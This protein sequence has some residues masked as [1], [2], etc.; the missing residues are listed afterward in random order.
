MPETSTAPCDGCPLQVERA[1]ASQGP[2]PAR[3]LFLSGAPRY[4]EEK[5]GVAFASPAFSWLEQTLAEA[6]LD[7]ATVHY[8]TLTGCRPPYQR[9]LRPAEIEACAPRLDLMINALQGA[10]VVLCGPDVAAAV[11]PGVA[12]ATGHGV[13]VRRGHRR[14]YPIRHPYAALLSARYGDEVKAD[15]RALVTL[16]AAGP[17]DLS[18]LPDL[19]ATAMH[20]PSEP[21]ANDGFPQPSPLPVITIAPDEPP[22]D[23]ADQADQLILVGAPIADGIPVEA[24]EAAE[25]IDAPAH[26]QLSAADDGSADVPAATAEVAPA[27]TDTDKDIDADGP[28]QLSLF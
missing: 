9:P 22:A 25:T 14:Y 26:D 19:A 6:G 18:T 7:P 27:V 4:H 15:L 16:L 21:A 3:V 12:L 2:V 10:V 28:T 5:E 23:Q 1:V 13:L 11:L 24:V 20:P 8:A 17:P